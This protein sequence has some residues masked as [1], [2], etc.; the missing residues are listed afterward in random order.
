MIW[1]K[2]IK[3]EVFLKAYE[4]FKNQIYHEKWNYHEDNI[5]STLVYK[6][7]NSMICINKVIYLYIVIIIL[8]PFNLLF[9]QT[10]MNLK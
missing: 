6:Y 5:W 8:Q 3:R 9:S 4:I 1:N 2:L 10:N 7:A